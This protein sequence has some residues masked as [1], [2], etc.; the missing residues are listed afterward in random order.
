VELSFR[1]VASQQVGQ[2]GPRVVFVRFLR[3]T[4]SSGRQSQRVSAAHRP[5]IPEPMFTWRCAILS[6][7]PLHRQGDALERQHPA[8]AA[9]DA[10]AA[11]KAV[12]AVDGLAAP[13][14]SRLGSRHRDTDDR[15]FQGRTGENRGDGSEDE[16]L[17]GQRPEQCKPKSYTSSGEP[18]GQQFPAGAEAPLESTKRPAEL[19]GRLVPCLPLQTAKN[20]GKR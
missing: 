6:R 16:A 4:S 10:F 18:R 13:G 11:G 14:G 17:N 7:L 1:D 19:L 3:V 20:Q 15:C 12:A 9:L 2:S 5:A 8:R